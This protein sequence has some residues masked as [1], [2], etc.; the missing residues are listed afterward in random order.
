MSRLSPFALDM[1]PARRGGM[2]TLSGLW[3]PLRQQAG[4]NDAAS[5]YARTFLTYSE[6][7]GG[8]VDE[9]WVCSRLERMSAYD[10]LQLLGRLSC[11]VLAAPFADVG[12]QVRIMRRLGW[13]QPFIKSVEA[14]LGLG[15]QS[16]S[17]FFPQQVV[18]LSRLAVLHADPRPPDHFVAGK[19][20]PEFLDCALG[21][22]ELLGEGDVD[23]GLEDN[24]VSW[25]LRQIAINGRLDSAALWTRYYEIF[26]RIWHEVPT[27]EVFEADAAFV[28]YTRL[29]IERWLTVGFG[30]YVQFLTYG[31]FGSD[32][33]GVDPAHY[34]AAT[35][36]NQTEWSSFLAQTGGT[37]DELRA[38]IVTEEQA[39]GPSVYRC[40]A[41]EKRPLLRFPG[42]LE[43]VVPI[44]LDS[45][46][47]R[48]TEGIFWI[49]SDGAM[50]E[51][52][53]REH[54][55]SAFGQVFEEWVQRAFERAIP[56][57]G[58]P[59]VHR[60]KPYKGPKGAVLDSTDVVLDYEP[61]A[62]FVEIV[63][64]R[65]MSATL[66]RGDPAAFRAD[67]EA[68][69]LKKARQLDRNVRD[70]REGRLVLGDMDPGRITQIF[71]VILSVEGFPS[72]PP[73][74]Q[75]VYREI[76][77]KGWL[78]GL[79]PVALVSGEDLAAIEALL[80]QGVALIELL[81]RWRLTPE[82]SALSFANFYDMSD[83]IK[84]KGESR[85]QHQGICWQALMS[86]IRGALFQRAGSDT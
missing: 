28:R 76:A 24:Q 50:N 72:M 69:V 55:T 71:P 19:L 38:E 77:A 49:L 27:P 22:T 75:I 2:S 31:S 48:V 25:I 1:A 57:V 13:P 79:P 23:L 14:K 33:F 82:F 47:R 8:A 30:L 34:F 32:D 11:M 63:S 4:G 51:G 60:A 66:T 74:S 65:P 16:R 83:D 56:T 21:V 85:S 5:R 20:L 84:A 70:F 12:Q 3:T 10:C 17:L 6:L 54:F 52:L 67:L 36:V 81:S 73:M 61:A 42:D 35:S 43:V 7:G 39:Y 59:R 78:H 44:A 18:H 15:M 9:Q 40:Q 29:G 41:F 80:E 46:E 26:A 68:G 62:V 58:T 86:H 53:N 64:K 45:Y 37:L